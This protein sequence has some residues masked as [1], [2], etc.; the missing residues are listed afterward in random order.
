MSSETIELDFRVEWGYSYLYSRRHYHPVYDWDGK[1]TA[2][3]GTITECRLLEYPKCWFGPAH[4]P[5]EIRLEKPEWVSR[6]RRGWSGIR[7]FAEADDRDTVF[8]VVTRS[9]SIRF[10]AG[11]ILG[12]GYMVFPIGPKFL[13]CTITVTRTGFLWFRPA[14][15]PGETVW[16][17]ADLPLPHRG[18][19]RREPGWIF[20][21]RSLELEID[22]PETRRDFAEALLHLELMGGKESPDGTEQQVFGY[23][24]YRLECDG[25]IVEES[26]QF[27]HRAN[28]SNGNFI[29]LLE[30]WWFRFRPSP[31]KHRIRFTNRH[32]EY[33]LLITKVAFSLHELDHLQLTLPPWALVGEPLSASVFAVRPDTAEI[34]WQGGTVTLS[35]RPGWNDFTFSFP[36]PGTDLPV[37]VNGKKFTIGAVYD[38][39]EEDPPVTVG[40]DLTVINHDD[41]GLLDWLLNYTWRTR[42]G[43]LIAFRSF[44]FRDPDGTPRPPDPALLE[45]WARYCRDHQLY[46]EAITHFEDGAIVR[47]AGDRLHTV[48]LHEYPGAVYAFD[49]ADGYRSQTMKEAMEHFL[50]YLRIEVDKAHDVAPRMAF[51]DA[52]GGHRYCYMAGADFIRSETLVP[53]TQ[54]LCSQAR[55]AAEAIG[56]G[57]WG[58]H[59]ASQHAF[60][61]LR[62]NHHLGCYYLSLLQPWLMGANMLY[63]EDNLFQLFKD[64]HQAWDDRLT[65]VKRDMIRD[66][67]RFAKT[68]PRK[69]EVRRRIAFWEGRYAA[70]FNG[71]IC[72]SEQ[73]PDY[74]V[75]GKFGN[76][77]P[78]WGHRQ[79][80]KCRQLLDVLM[81]GASTHPLRQRFDRIRFYFSG[82]PYGDFDEVPAEASA[83]YLSRYKLLLNLGWN[84][85]IDEDYEK[86]R[87]FVADGGVLLTGIPQFSTHVR[88]DFLRDMSDL[89]LYRGGDLAD[90]CGIRVK[91]AGKPYSGQWNAA[92][93]EKYPPQLLSAMPSRSLTE[94]GECLLADIEPA[95]AETAAWDADNDSP[96]LTRFRLGKGLVYTFTAWV[97]PGHEQ[98]QSTA[99][100]IIA[101]LADEYKGEIWIDDPSREV[102]WNVREMAGGALL[103][104]LN[105]DWSLPGGAKPVTV[106]HPDGRFRTEVIERQVKFILFHRRCAVEYGGE[107][108][109]ELLGGGTIRFHGT[110]RRSVILHRPDG[111]T[112]RQIDF[113]NAVTAD[114]R[115]E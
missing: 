107:L 40:Y 60:Q 20:P 12:K 42:M 106:N 33:S 8:T 89:A 49:P 2:D 15:K 55:P 37:T 61:P 83:E 26:S 105:T 34:R 76:E 78:E 56:K 111:D 87:K 32:E 99:A 23:F 44:L 10:T 90:L 1:I 5:R 3:R 19:A 65:K 102:F 54:H 72:G 71:F 69:G 67:L 94:D 84:T 17:A 28:K 93:R 80:E 13:G 82:T 48:G 108:H 68:H 95:G 62:E 24:P 91:G 50:D 30:D 35:L 21:G 58:V 18:F 85:M 74:S 31:G 79:P 6:T 98:F 41:R 47:G 101:K 115:L 114:L 7:C 88:R 22:V 109:A 66:F 16:D 53:H 75:W 110:G 77:A 36:G 103:S 11:D 51:G 64:E 46:V 4:C 27:L 52:S 39:P 112:V 100:E 86:L 57:E 14:P 25:E 92:D 38:L 29:Q 73:T 104:M 113:G 43:N 97:Y 45:K 70:P 59:I 9:G 63:D 81:P 96:V